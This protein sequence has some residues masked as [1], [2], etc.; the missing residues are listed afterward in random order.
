MSPASHEHSLKQS[1]AHNRMAPE[2]LIVSIPHRLG[3][4]EAARRLKTGLDRAAQQF[5]SVLTI[6]QENWDADRLTFQATALNQ[7]IAGTID[8]MENAVRLEV[9]LP[10]LLARL[11][12]GLRD[13]IAQR[14]ALMLEKK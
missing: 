13:T 1:A 2:P 4:D 8:V 6:D 7:K 11:A 14:G 10:W 9:S 3:K 5:S 12:T